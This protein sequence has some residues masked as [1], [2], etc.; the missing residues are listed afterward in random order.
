LYYGFQ[1]RSLFAEGLG[2]FRLVPY[3]GLTQFEFYFRQPFSLDGIV[4]DTPSARR[5]VAAGHQAG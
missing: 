1:C 5:C 3:P 2:F 4:K